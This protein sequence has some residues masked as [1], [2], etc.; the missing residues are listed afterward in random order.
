VAFKCLL[1]SS[2]V[3]ERIPE[4]IRYCKKWFGGARCQN[5]DLYFSPSG[6]GFNVPD[7]LSLF[8]ECQLQQAHTLKYILSIRIL[9]LCLQKLL[10]SFRNSRSVGDQHRWKA[11]LEISTWESRAMTTVGSDSWSNMSSK[12]QRQ[13]ISRLVPILFCDISDFLYWLWS[14]RLRSLENFWRKWMSFF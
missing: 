14:Y 1:S 11:Y 4:Y 10:L 13:Y 8:H 9:E 7:I 3:V 5:A 12:Q 6:F 2:F